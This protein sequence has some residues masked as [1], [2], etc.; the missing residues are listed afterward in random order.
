MITL[1]KFIYINILYLKFYMY[2]EKLKLV[3]R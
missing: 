1:I 3:L 2:N